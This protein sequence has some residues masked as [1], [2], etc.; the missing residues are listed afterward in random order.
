VQRA[1]RMVRSPGRRLDARPDSADFRD[2]LYTPG[3]LEVP[4]VL[5]LA[6]YQRV[7]V[8]ILDQGDEG[9]CTGF[10][11]AT[12]ANYLLRARKIQPEKSAS[13]SPRMLYELAKRYDEWPGRSY[14]GSSCR[15]AVKGWQKHGVCRESLWRHSSHTRHTL[16]ETRRRDAARRP[17][18][19]YYRVNVKSLTDMH[20]ALAEVGVL[21]VSSDVHAGWDAVRRN[22]SIPSRKQIVGGHAY[23]L[24]G[25]DEV[26]FWLQNSWGPGWGKG[27]FARLGYDD[28]LRDGADAWICRLGVPVRVKPR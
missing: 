8:P 5:P 11:L 28:W 25:F 20:A 19:A 1:R 13:V 12:V 23:A 10:G 17:L 21:Y 7:E 4:P 9:A 3:L 18:G 27:G 2:H 15:G 16:T 14:E 22:G 26:G 24:V 6:H